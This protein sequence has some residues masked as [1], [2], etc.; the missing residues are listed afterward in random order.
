MNGHSTDGADGGMGE[1]RG[2]AFLRGERKKQTYSIAGK[3]RGP[4]GCG[5]VK[6]GGKARVLYFGKGGEGI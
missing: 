3:K 2:V 6:K 5:K 1:K 4:G